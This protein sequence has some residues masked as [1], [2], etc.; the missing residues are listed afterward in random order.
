MGV[1]A[2]PELFAIWAGAHL[3]KTLS[4]VSLVSSDEPEASATGLS[5]ADASG[6]SVTPRLHPGRTSPPFF[7]ANSRLAVKNGGIAT[8]CRTR[9]YFF[10]A[11]PP[12]HCDAARLRSSSPTAR[13]THGFWRAGLAS[14]SPGAI[15][16][17]GL[18]ASSPNICAHTPAAG[19]TQRRL[20][21][22]GADH[23]SLPEATLPRGEQN[24]SGVPLSMWGRHGSD[25]DSWHGLMEFPRNERIHQIALQEP[26][27]N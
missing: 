3:R 7:T 1:L 18:L 10:T 16:T 4:I 15:R 19:V 5:V 23:M 13:Q 9:T 14:V 17:C 8:S 11:L 27:H 22:A 12:T 6:S 26:I 24:D 25:R 21:P 20:L 2:L